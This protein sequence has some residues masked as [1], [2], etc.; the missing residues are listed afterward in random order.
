MKYLLARL[1]ERS[2]IVTLLSLGLGFVGIE[3]SP[4][5]KEAIVGGVIAVL[6]AIGIFTREK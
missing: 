5:H 4:D 6:S 2:T 1:F 3:L